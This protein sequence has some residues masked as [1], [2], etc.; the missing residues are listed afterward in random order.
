MQEK[1]KVIQTESS[2]QLAEQFHSEL[3]ISL[4]TLGLAHYHLRRH[5]LYELG[6]IPTMKVK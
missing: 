3:H 5:H 6:H 4:L 2:T 1:P